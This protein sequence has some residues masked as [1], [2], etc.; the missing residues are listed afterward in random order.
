[1]YPGEGN[2]AVTVQFRLVVFRP[3]EGELLVG[4]VKSST[5]EGIVVS[6]NF[7]EHVFIPRDGLKDQCA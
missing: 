4:R 5:V 7:F 1:M 6:M 3:F 2:T